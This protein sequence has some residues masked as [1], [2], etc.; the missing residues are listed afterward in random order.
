MLKICSKVIQYKKL[1][2]T[3]SARRLL[4]RPSGRGTPILPTTPFTSAACRSRQGTIGP[5]A[6]LSAAPYSTLHRC[7]RTDAKPRFIFIIKPG[8]QTMSS[9]ISQAEVADRR[10]AAKQTAPKNI[11]LFYDEKFTFI[12][13]VYEHVHAFKKHSRHRVFYAP[14][15]IVGAIGGK[16]YVED[17][18]DDF[19]DDSTSTWNL[20]I[21]DAVIIHYSV[22]L[23]YKGYI[24]PQ[25]CK[26]IREYQGPK[27]LFIQDEYE[28]VNTSR[29]YIEDLGITAI[30]TCVPP[31][32]LDAVYPRSRFPELEFIQT[33]TGYIPEAGDLE[34]FAMPLHKRPTLIGYRGRRLP[35][36]YGRLGFEKFIIGERI[37]EE[38][39]KRGLNVDIESDASKRVYGSWYKFLGSCRATLGTES[40]CNIF[41]FDGTLAAK[42]QRLADVPFEVAYPQHFQ[43]H[44]DLVMMNQ[45]SPKFFEAI[46]LRTAL[47]C[48]P[49]SYSGILQAGRHFIALE[50]DFSNIDQ[51]FTQLEDFDFL[52]ELTNRSY[53]EIVQSGLYTYSAFISAFDD[54]IDGKVSSSRADIIMAPIAVRRGEKISPIRHDQLA[55]YLLNDHVLGGDWERSQFCDLFESNYSETSQ[56]KVDRAKAEHGASIAASTPFHGRPNDA[57]CLLR[58]FVNLN[59][60]AAISSEPLPHFIEIELGSPR[61]I[62]GMSLEWF[63]VTNFGVNYK[64][65]GAGREGVWA[66]LLTILGNKKV[67]PSYD[68]AAAEVSRVRFTVTEIEGQ[69]RILLRRFELYER[70]D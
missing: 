20:G 8:F 34:D 43:E 53:K 68:F 44:E 41:D 56:R 5:L 64:L 19:A 23:A 1:R 70:D 67:K 11:L 40:G 47:V 66:E 9:E 31:E 32:G 21:Y 10:E 58:P 51:V 50:K 36:H 54:W 35:H 22:R 69:Q 48:F 27:V 65:E 33:L 49:G 45:I 39:F 62:S 52:E 59:Y 57:D 7:D 18:S 13:T 37:R 26:I 60:A 3:V 63:D 25:V 30:Y 55:D 61:R 14:G 4:K 29:D 38:A 12:N 17:T 42:A 16:R 28:Y 2:C 15:T 24:A 46:R 6:K